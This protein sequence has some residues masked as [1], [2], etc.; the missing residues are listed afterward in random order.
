MQGQEL[1]ILDHKVRMI[2]RLHRKL[3]DTEQRDYI[4]QLLLIIKYIVK[5]YLEYLVPVFAKQDIEYDIFLLWQ[6][7]FLTQNRSIVTLEDDSIAR[8]VSLLT[9]I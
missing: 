4:F 2:I 5:V 9:K 6:S 7:V 8:L 1:I 3:E